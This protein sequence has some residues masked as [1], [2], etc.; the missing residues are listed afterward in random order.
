MSLGPHALTSLNEVKAALRLTAIDHDEE[1]KRRINAVTDRFELFTR[2]KLKAR[3][4]KPSGAAAGEENLLLNG[5]DRL[6]DKAFLFPEWPV[7]SIT[8]LTIKDSDLADPEVVDVAKLIIDNSIPGRIILLEDDRIWRKGQNNIEATWNG[9]LDPVP[10]ELEDLCIKQ[11]VQDFLERD[12]GREG[13]SSLSTSGESVTYTP[14]NLMMDVEHGLE[15]Y[16]R[17]LGA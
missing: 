8:A 13:V 17:M 11:V 7:N 6:T 1:L 2:R 12:R 16:R 14:R 10:A 3:T 5:D 4:Y 9:G 15:R